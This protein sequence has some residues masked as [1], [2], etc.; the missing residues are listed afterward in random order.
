MI[1][2]AYHLCKAEPFPNAPLTLQ[3]LRIT[4]Q[5]LAATFIFLVFL[6]LH[7]EQYDGVNF[8]PPLI[9]SIGLVLVDLE[10]RRGEDRVGMSFFLQVRHVSREDELE[11]L[12]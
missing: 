4:I 10:H 9:I 11:L 12:L 7:T 2:S 1:T 8:P 5:L 3:L 6:T